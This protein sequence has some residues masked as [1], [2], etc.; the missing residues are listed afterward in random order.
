MTCDMN[1]IL[2]GSL[3]GVVTQAMS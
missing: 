3:V 1:R 2:R